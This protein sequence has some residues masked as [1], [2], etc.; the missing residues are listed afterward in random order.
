MKKNERDNINRK[1][2]IQAVLDNKENGITYLNKINERL[3]KSKG[4]AEKVAIL[5]DLLFISERT[6]YNDYISTAMTERTNEKIR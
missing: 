3:E 6:I 5:N 4:T 2:F 1:A